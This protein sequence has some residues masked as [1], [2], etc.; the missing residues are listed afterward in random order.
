MAYYITNQCWTRKLGPIIIHATKTSSILALPG[1]GPTS[2]S[3]SLSAPGTVFFL[4]IYNPI[5]AAGDASNSGNGETFIARVYTV[6]A[7][8]VPTFLTWSTDSSK[9]ALV[10]AKASSSLTDPAQAILIQKNGCCW[11][12]SQPTGTPPASRTITA[13]T[14]LA[15]LAVGTGRVTIGTATA[16]ACGNF[17]FVAV[18]TV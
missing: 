15:T 18:A 5:I 16:P 14:P 7:A 11:T 1:V 10:G 2:A 4:D 13:S 17:Q 12:W 6:S 9:T 8:G 3:P